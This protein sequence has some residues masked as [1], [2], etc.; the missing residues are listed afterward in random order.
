MAAEDSAGKEDS[1]LPA[2]AGGRSRGQ[3][4]WTLLPPPREIT[5]TFNFK[6]PASRLACRVTVAGRASPVTGQLIGYSQLKK[7]VAEA[8]Q[9]QGGVFLGD[10]LDKENAPLPGGAPGRSTARSSGESRALARLL[11]PF[12]CRLLSLEKSVLGNFF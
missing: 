2:G 5:A 12:A 8:L 10:G 6:F 4:G 3:D 1:L 7:L 11:A 9:E